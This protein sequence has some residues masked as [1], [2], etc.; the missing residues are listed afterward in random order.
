MRFAVFILLALRAS[1]AVLQGIVTDD[2]TGNVLARTTVTLTPLATSK[3]AADVTPLTIRSGDRGAFSMLSVRPG[4]Y[5]LKASRPGY[6][7]AEAGQLRPG[8]PGMPFEILPDTQSTFVQLR[9]KHLAAIA[10]SLL[11][12]N[13]VG[14]PDLP[15]HVYTARRPVRRIAEGKTDDRGVYRIGSLDPGR[16]LVRSGPGQL[17]DSSGVIPTY[18]K[19]GLALETAE[20]V[21]LRLGETLPD[22]VIRP[23]SGKLLTLR[24]ILSPSPR[25]PDSPVR[26]T[27]I[28]DTGRCLTASSAGPFEIPNVPPGPIELV[29]DGFECGSYSKLIMDR[30]M[31]DLR[32]GCN[33]L[34]PPAVDWLVTG[35][36]RASITYPLLARRVDLDGASAPR[37]FRTNELILPG[38]YELMV[39]T[40]PK[41]YAQS[42]RMNFAG[43]VT[44]EDGW[45]GAD[46]GNQVRLAITLSETPAA[47][48]G[49]VTA[50][51]KPVAGA[52]VFMELFNQDAV[53]PR[54]QLWTARSDATGKYTFSGLTPG[55]YRLLSTFDFD[56][57]DR[58]AMQKAK[59]IKLADAE[60]GVADLEL[61]LP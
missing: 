28:T 17:E 14:L 23:Q 42:M 16:Y 61:Q 40:G 58:F 6:A 41:H 51:G 53:E 43:T 34:Y 29:A 45:F 46:F 49:L 10:G 57:E 44:R 1:A 26:L 32:I 52:L 38:H 18:Y 11:D 24:G 27:L 21:T 9:M 20:A 36:P 59:P 13:G 15:V 50:N 48:T 12:E 7:D 47:V 30:D 2:E 56:P 60:T 25:R 22:V 55:R 8:R 39:Q 37:V 4:W 35:R 19:F 31:T 54:L 33:P 3:P 5:V